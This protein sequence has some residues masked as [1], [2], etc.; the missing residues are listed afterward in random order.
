MLDDKFLYPSHDRHRFSN[1]DSS[2]CYELTFSD[3][4]FIGVHETLS[5][6]STGMSLFDHAMELIQPCLPVIAFSK[7]GQ[8]G[9][10][11]CEELKRIGMSV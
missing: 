5:C 2:I 1:D 7:A 11:K 3:F 8:V 6:I 4:F 9:M 10:R